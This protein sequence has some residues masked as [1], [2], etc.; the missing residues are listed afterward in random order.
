MR[1]GLDVRYISHGLTG[2]VRTYVYHLAR[3]LPRC[4]PGHEFYFYADDKAPLELTGLPANVVVRVL[5]WRGMLSSVRNDVLLGRWMER[6]GVDLAHCPGNYGPRTRVPLV[7]TLHDALNVFSMSQHLRGFGRRPRQV[8]MMMYLGRMTRTTLR[9]A[10]RVITVSEHARRDIAARTGYPLERIVAI[11]EAAGDEFT[12]IQDSDALERVRRQFDLGSR[13]I[14]ADGIKNPAAVIDAHGRLPE[15]LLRATQLV[16]FSREPAPRPP[17]AAALQLQK[18]GV[19]F[20]PRPTTTEL[21]ALMNLATVF[22]FP[23][24][25]EGFGLPLVEAMRCGAPIVASSRGSIPEVVGDAG[26]IFDL[27][28]PRQFTDQLVLMLEDE[29]TR[30]ELRARALERAAR[31]TWR[32]T[33]RQTVGVYEEVASRLQRTA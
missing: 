15:H 8:A 31:F 30:R 25:Y 27:E 9:R 18:P 33:A 29:S 5:P 22:A 10:S 16:F 14:L 28:E 12:V 3:E 21:V 20:I 17:V 19:R 1:I 26:L 7:V 24:W 11:H 13:I 23:S 4:A 6:D 2:G 32:R